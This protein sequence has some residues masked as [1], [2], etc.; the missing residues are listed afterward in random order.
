MQKNFIGNILLHTYLEI[1][2]LLSLLVLVFFPRS[3]TPEFS[4]QVVLVY[5]VIELFNT[6]LRICFGSLYIGIHRLS[7]FQ[8]NLLQFLRVSKTSSDNFLLEAKD[9]V[10]RLA[11][12]L[13]FLSC[14]KS[15]Q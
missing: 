4:L 2:G 8:F 9:G 1:D 10:P 5:I 3:Q 11:D 13:D 7:Y 6:D 14:P 12:F 15:N